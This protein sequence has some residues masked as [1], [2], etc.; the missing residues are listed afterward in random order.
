MEKKDIKETRLK[1]ETTYFVA[2]EE[3]PLLIY[4]RIMKL[5][6]KAWYT[7]HLNE[8]TGVVF[9]DTIASNLVKE[10]KI[11]ILQVLMK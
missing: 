3:L 11:K 5:E 7:S 6:K 2:I 1:F 9:I 10:L 4:P 8:N